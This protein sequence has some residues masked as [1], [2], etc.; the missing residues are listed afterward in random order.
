MPISDSWLLSDEIRYLP[1]E[2]SEEPDEWLFELIVRF[3]GNIVVLKVLLSVESDLLG[4]DFS[5]LNIDLVS[6]QDDGDVLANSD[7]ILVPLGNILV[8]NS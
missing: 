3:G 1:D 6:N 8:G 4:L 7:E 5:V 2:S